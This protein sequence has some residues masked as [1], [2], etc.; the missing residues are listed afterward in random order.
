MYKKLS[1]KREVFC[2]SDFFSGSTDIYY[3]GNGVIHKDF[4][5]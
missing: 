3:N 5:D 1:I 2:A 4:M